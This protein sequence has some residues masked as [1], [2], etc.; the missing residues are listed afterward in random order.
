MKNEYVFD[1]R[2]AFWWALAEAKGATNI[3]VYYDG[4]QYQAEYVTASK[5]VESLIAELQQKSSRV[6]EVYSLNLPLGPQQADPKA[7]NLD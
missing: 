7:W 5:T 2:L 6:I 3:V 4:D 1:N